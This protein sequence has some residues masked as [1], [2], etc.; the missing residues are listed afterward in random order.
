MV[1]GLRIG[2]VNSQGLGEDNWKV[3]QR[4][5]EEGRLDLLF[6]AETWFLGWNRYSA[7]KH[8]IAATPRPESRNGARYTGGMCLL[9]TPTARARLRREPD[10][11]ESIM[12]AHLDDGIVSGVY[13]PPSMRL[14]AV[15]EVLRQAG[16]SD[17]VLGD[18]NVHFGSRPGKGTPPDRAQLVVEWMQESGLFHVQP[19][20][21]LCPWMGMPV[22]SSLTVDH[23]FARRLPTPPALHLLDRRGLGLSTDHKYM[24]LVVRGN[25][26][27]SSRRSNGPGDGPSV[28]LP[29]FG[30]RMLERRGGVQ[31][32]Q[33]CWAV[34]LPKWEP[35]LASPPDDVDVFNDG[36]VR[37]CQE[38]AEQA[39]GKAPTNGSAYLRRPLHPAHDQSAMG[40]HTLMRQAQA[41]D[42]GNGVLL[43]TKPGDD[44]VEEIRER[45]QARYTGSTER[46]DGGTSTSR[47]RVDEWRHP[48]ITVD[49]VVAEIAKQEASKACGV[50]GIH[51]RIMKALRDT[52]F[53]SWLAVLYNA[54]LA[55]SRT[56][57][58]WNSTVVQ[59]IVKDKA[60]PKTPTNVRPITLIC[61]FRKVFECLLL[62]QFCD[63]E[64]KDWARVHAAQAGFRRSLSTL[65]HAALLH[66]SLERKRVGSVVFLDFRAAFD[67]VDHGLLRRTLAARGCPRQIQEVVA[68]LMF[69]DVSS[70]I[71]ANG[72]VSHSFP[73]TCGVLQG[74]PLSPALFNLFVDGLLRRL[75]GP[76][77]E[78]P[79]A[80][81]YADD[82]VL[83]AYPGV[84]VQALLDQVYVWTQENKMEL[85]VQKCGHLTRGAASAPVFWGGKEI[86][87]VSGY[88]YL[89][90]PVTGQG[91]DFE[92]YIRGRIEA[93]VRYTAVLGLHS[94]SWG[95]AHRLR[96]YRQY[97]A[98]IFEYGAPLVWTWSQT[99]AEA[100][101][102]WI[103]A[104]RAWKDLVCWIADSQARWVVTANLL[105]LPSLKQRF[106]I[107]HAAYMLRLQE[108]HDDDPLRKA[109]SSDFPKSSFGY[110]LRQSPYFERW[111]VACPAVKDPQRSLGHFLIRCQR[112]AIAETAESRHLTTIVPFDS[113]LTRGL[114]F[115]DAT[116][117]APL[118]LQSVLLQY[119]R[120]L[121]QFH[122]IHRCKF[123]REGREF[124]R[125]DEECR[126]FRLRSWLSRKQR[127]Q[128][129]QEGNLFR[130]KMR[131]T[132]VDFLLNHGEFKRA[133]QILRDVQNQLIKYDSCI[134]QK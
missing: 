122:R 16:K 10:V 47:A 32:L 116:L 83:L 41:D 90:F 111:K 102:R 20:S 66:M 110:R 119:R 52:S 132:E 1:A 11:G 109:L 37:L 19:V 125:G 30:V 114:R 130:S 67:V 38:V 59:L 31:R 28:M 75:N 94:R 103:D 51:I 56:P 42:A 71:L 68:S 80:L 64:G 58:A 33:D 9:G 82:G 46:N 23:C 49:H 4:W 14:G 112:E 40:T 113:R 53:P 127:L 133:G 84:S 126:C 134:E 45:L 27:Q 7:W 50:D 48:E 76:G 124:R 18:V 89:G 2:Y 92:S 54:C 128:K 34:A 62:K 98:P 60:S 93:A 105:G 131:F 123:T 6:V 15:E 107:L 115:A 26:G 5:I 21:G 97:L 77:V 120:G 108:A 74:S 79:R 78:M 3:C 29:R 118:H 117:E 43:P 13:L 87:R 104:T 35:M 25:D 129:R 91:I 24:L 73:R 17:L 63:D 99:G 85:N 72:Q 86:P 65:T 12:S 22:C 96:V 36:L 61:M 100:A 8:T 39:L 101:K 121:W 70:R 44:A 81:F 57:Q 55:R 88:K 69:S 95:P 106:E